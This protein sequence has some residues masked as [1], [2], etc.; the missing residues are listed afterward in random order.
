[1]IKLL[2]INSKPDLSFFIKR[3]LQFDISYDTC[4]KIFPT[5]KTQT[6]TTADNKIVT[7]F[8]PDVSQYIET[9]YPNTKYDVIIFGW[10]PKDYSSE[11][12][13]TGG[14]TFRNKL[15]NGAY[16]IT[17]RQDGQNYEV[18]ELMHAIGQILYIDL[19]KYDAV[20]QMDTTFIGNTPYHYYHNDQPEN[21]DSNFG[22]TWETY[23][24]YL[25]ELNS[26]GNMPTVTI[27]RNKSTTKETTGV[28][29]ATNSG[30]TFTCKTLE[31]PWLDNKKMIS[32]IPKGTYRVK[33]V[34]WTKK[35]RSYYQVQNVPGR[36]GI[37]MHPGNFHFNFEGC[38]GLGAK[39]GDINNDSEVDI[40]STV[41]TVAAFEAFMQKKPFTLVIR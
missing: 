1:M 30:A 38:I 40:T 6:A 36:S 21:L 18:H 19:K 29:T 14:Q 33:K 15:S 28:L 3:G 23:K 4:A 22:I 10:N 9:T 34:F 24:K 13:S 27:K 25:P 20:D 26:L 11:F 2:C 8:S 37:F 17:A 41:A 32:C 7:I 12:N 39:F 5:I 35:L 16:L 31:L